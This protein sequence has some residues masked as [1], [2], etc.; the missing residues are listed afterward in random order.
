MATSPNLSSRF[1]ARR[2]RPF[3]GDGRRSRDE[4]KVL[5]RYEMIKVLRSS[6][7]KKKKKKTETH[8]ATCD[9][10]HQIRIFR[11]F[12]LFY[13]ITYPTSVPLAHALNSRAK[14]RRSALARL[15]IANQLR[16][17]NQTRECLP[18]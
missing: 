11:L 15:S 2:L 12:F 6:A 9:R 10:Q 3:A 5:D 17:N 16:K 4:Y 7:K 18:I 8:R 14:I 1:S 13:Y